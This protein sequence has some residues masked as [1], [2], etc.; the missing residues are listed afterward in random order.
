[1]CAKIALTIYTT[2]LTDP[3]GIAARVPTG[4]GSVQIFI[5][6]SSFLIAF[7]QEAIDAS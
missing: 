5:P 7:S 3:N 6:H 1:V 4:H 2:V